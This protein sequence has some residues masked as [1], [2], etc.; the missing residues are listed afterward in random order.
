[1][2]VQGERHLRKILRQYIGY[3][4]ESRTHLDL[5]KDCPVSS[6]TQVPEIGGIKSEPML[7]GLHHRYF[8][9]VAE[10][11]LIFPM[12]KKLLDRST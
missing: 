1:V 11:I 4:H 7:G 5:E 10:E 8:R 9:E 6:E 2:I 12:E 3:Y